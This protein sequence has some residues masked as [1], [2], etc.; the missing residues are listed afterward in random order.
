M[1]I[2]V[3]QTRLPYGMMVK[4]HIL[5][6]LRDNLLRASQTHS[7]KSPLRENVNNVGKPILGYLVGLLPQ[8]FVVKVVRVSGYMRTY[9]KNHL[10]EIS[11]VLRILS[12]RAGLD[13]LLAIDSCSDQIILGQTIRV[14]FKNID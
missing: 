3:L 10:Q 6:T 1:R 4:C 7:R 13:M 14:M 12:G 8:D 11:A 5:G 9:R 2:S